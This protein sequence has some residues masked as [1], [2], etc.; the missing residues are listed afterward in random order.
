LK[1]MVG[2]RRVPFAQ[3]HSMI[4]IHAVFVEEPN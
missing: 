3:I 1:M 2:W 4:E